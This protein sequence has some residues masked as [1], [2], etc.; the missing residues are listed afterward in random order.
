MRLSVLFLAC[1]VSLYPQE[2][3]DVAA[4][5]KQTTESLKKHK[6]YQMSTEI[7]VDMTV[8]GNPVRMVMTSDVSAINPDRARV[9]SKA[10]MG[11]GATIVSTG[12]FTYM[13]IPA[14]K[15][16]TKKAALSS[17]QQMFS[18]TGMTS[19]PDEAKLV[20]NSRVIR[21]ETIEA[22]GSEHP[23]WV[24]ETKIDK[25]PLAAPITGA[26]TDSVI[27]MWIGQKDNIAWRSTMSGKMQAGPMTT[28]MKQEMRLHSV[29]LDPALPDSLFMFVP[30]EGAKEVPDFGGPAMKKADLKGKPAP[31]FALK[32]IDGKAFDSAA[33][34][35]KPVLLD[36]WTTWCG[37]CRKE[38]PALDRIHTEFKDAGLVLI[39]VNVGEDR[40]LVEKSLKTV[41]P[42]Y[43]I[44]LSNDSDIVAA[45]QVTAFPTYVLIGSVGTIAAH[46]IGSSGEDSLR[47]MLGNAGV[48]SKTK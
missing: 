5:I 18:N 35:G 44:A 31:A 43:P 39:G 37:P 4:L 42:A 2:L 8:A 16:Y 40:A 7:T 46:Q 17:P 10:S 6:S 34:K 11:G 32:S 28:D 38:M 29:K 15:Q 9:E 48:K 3:P 1:F 26:L 12:E 45:F 22:D 20:Q 24:V 25:L 47:K 14:L 19:L 13:Y 33:L 27:T 30:P 36:F 21:Q 41:S 23:C